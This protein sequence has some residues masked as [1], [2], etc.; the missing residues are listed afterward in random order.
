M[1]GNFKGALTVGAVAAL[2]MMGATTGALA[3][4]IL[5]GV[6]TAYTCAAGTCSYGA[7]ATGQTDAQFQF[8][9]PQW[10][11]LGTPTGQTLTG[12][13]V[14]ISGSY[15]THGSVTATGTVDAQAVSI[16]TDN[17]TT[18]GLAGTTIVGA[19]SSGL[20]GNSPSSVNFNVSSGDLLSNQ[21]VGTILAGNSSPVSF[22]KLFTLVN[23]GSIDAALVGAGNY[24]VVFGTSTYVT[25]GA[26]SGNVQQTV[27]TDETL[28]LA[29]A[30]HYVE[31]PPPGVP[32]PA[33]MALLGTGL[34][35][36][37]MMIRRR[38]RS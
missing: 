30:Y 28:N 17:I 35:G 1:L 5:A 18:S 22:S 29:L 10:G 34:L 14:T 8:D 2:G 21:V 25:T 19:F 24:T 23:L 33:S 11:S 38:R 15:T 37:G 36:L 3:S 9:I 20:N 26:S 13:T 31:T 27:T 6:T 16:S 32:E 7:T 12:M 4:P